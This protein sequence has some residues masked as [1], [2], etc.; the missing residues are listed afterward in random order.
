MDSIEQFIHGIEKYGYKLGDR[1]I[2]AFHRY[3]AEIQRLNDRLGLISP[4][5]L[6]R[7]PTRHF[8]DSVMP[9][10]IGIMPAG[11]AIID[12][13]SGG[14]FPGIPLAILMPETE[15]VLV[16]S[17][18]KKSNFLRQVKRALALENVTVCNNRVENLPDNE[19]GV[20]YDGAVARAVGTVSQLTSWSG[21]VLK[22]GARLICYKGPSPAEEINAAKTI[23]DEQGMVWEGTFSYDDE[24]HDSP[25]LVVFEKRQE[26]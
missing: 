8:L 3:L 2:E 6:H 11:G 26:G 7:T 21:R 5:D 13:G 19:T 4:S 25:T 23:L 12:I 10:V 22:P 14:G 17:N 24:Q 1:K 9:A 20:L 15:I 18:R 16:E